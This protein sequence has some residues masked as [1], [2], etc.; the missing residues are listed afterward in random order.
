MKTSHLL[1][2]GAI[3]AVAVWYFFIRTPSAA[4]TATTT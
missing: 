3:G 4:V 1:I 2:L